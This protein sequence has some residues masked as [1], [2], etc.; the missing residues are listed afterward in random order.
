MP[1]GWKG[2]WGLALILGECCF[3]RKLVQPVGLRL[4]PGWTESPLNIPQTKPGAAHCWGLLR[5][6]GQA[7]RG[8]CCHDV[9]PLGKVQ[10]TPRTYLENY[11]HGLLTI[12]GSSFGWWFC[13]LI[14]TVGFLHSKGE[15]SCWSPKVSC[16]TL[17][18]PTTLSLKSIAGSRPT[19]SHYLRLRNSLREYM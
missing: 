15:L 18:F 12:S 4:H 14:C 5:S 13:D 17:H 7:F 9:F 6:A 8:C 19:P 16:W 3:P 1:V 11:R 2:F 10:R